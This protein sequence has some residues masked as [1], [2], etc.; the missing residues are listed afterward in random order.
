MNII[1][2]VVLAVAVVV[3]VVAVHTLLQLAYHNFQGAI[4]TSCHLRSPSPEH[5]WWEREEIHF[6]WESDRYGKKAWFFGG[7][8]SLKYQVLPQIYLQSG[9]AGW[10]KG[11]VTCFLEVPLACLGSMAAA[12]QPNCLWNSQ[13][14]CRPRL[15]RGFADHDLGSSPGWL[16]DTVATYCPGRPSQLKLK[17]ITKPCD[18]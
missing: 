12:V 5:T 18:R 8:N 16:A 10:E 2:T 4:L 1:S 17:H 6:I 9:A 7:Q 13:K 11:L 3:V 15:Y 14:I